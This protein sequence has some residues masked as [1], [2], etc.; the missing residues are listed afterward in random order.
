MPDPNEIT[1]GDTPQVA[2]IRARLD[3]QRR[4]AFTQRK[5]A[6]AAP[7]P[8]SRYKTCYVVADGVNPEIYS[9]LPVL[10]AL[11]LSDTGARLHSVVEDEVGL[12]DMVAQRYYGAGYEVLWW[13]IAY[14][15]GITDPT[16]DLYPG[17]T[18]L[19]PSQSVVT[20]FLLQRS[21]AASETR[22]E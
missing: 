3:A 12:L 17:K 8:T 15:N 10:D 7:A 18:L 14:A 4:K 21:K 13:L 5:S 6:E 20:A 9:P 19:I 2:A 11:L 16:L 1:S 22:T